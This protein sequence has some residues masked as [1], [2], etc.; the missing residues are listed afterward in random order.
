MAA[1]DPATVQWIQDKVA[2]AKSMNAIPV[3]TFYALLKLGQQAG[4]SGTGPQ[5]VQQTLQNP[6]LMNTYFNQFISVLN[7]VANSNTPVIV[8]IEPDSW[9]FMVWAMGIEGNPD[10]TSVLVKVQSSGHPDVVGFPDHADGLGHALLKLRN[11]YAP[12]VRLG[13]HASNFRV[14]SGANIMVSFYSSMGEYDVLF[15]ESPHNEADPTQ[16]WLPWDE[17]RVQKNLD[18]FST[19][20]N[21]AHI[22]V[23]LWQMPIGT[24]DFHL[25]TSDPTMRK[26]FSQ[27]GIAGVLFELLGSGN[28]DDFRAMEADLATIPPPN[29]LAGGTAKDMRIRLAVYSQQPLP[30]PAGSICDSGRIF[31]RWI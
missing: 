21:A 29:M 3:I 24:T 5:V 30:W 9:G 25:F 17:L 6:T 13:W 2:L 27:A 4:I 7:A 18:F 20:T 11:Q 1:N 19:L 16:W 22:P 23:L 15:G 14:G 8:Q 31:F 10:A 26:R 12:S 28:P